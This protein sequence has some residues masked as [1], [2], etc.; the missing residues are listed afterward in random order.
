MVLHKVMRP[1]WQNHTVYCLEGRKTHWIA[2]HTITLS[3]WFPQ[4][5]CH[6]SSLCCHHF[7]C[8]HLTYHHTASFPFSSTVVGHNKRKREHKRSG[9]VSKRND[10]ASAHRDDVREIHMWAFWRSVSVQ[11]PKHCLRL[12][13]SNVNNV[14]ESLVTFSTNIE[15]T[16]VN[17][18]MTIIEIYSP[19]VCR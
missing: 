9:R 13:I 7:T 5:V 15:A 8:H 6:M 11:T 1:T 17:E 18:R 3:S 10:V 2:L 16:R 19:H 14:H 12:V 4:Y